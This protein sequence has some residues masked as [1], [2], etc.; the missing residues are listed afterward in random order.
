[1]NDEMLIELVSE[2]S[3]LFDL[4]NPKYMDTEY[5]NGIWNKI[6]I[7]MKMDGSSCKS[8]WNNIRD[9]YRKSLK[10]NKTVS[11]QKGKAAR[12]YKFSQHLSF[13]TNFFEDMDTI[14]NIDSETNQDSM[15]HDEVGEEKAATTSA[16]IS[17]LCEVSHSH[18]SPST[19]RSYKQSPSRMPKDGATPI[20]YTQSPR[21]K[22]RQFQQ[23]TTPSKIT[24]TAVLD[25][26]VRQKEF[27]ASPS[28]P[29]NE[30]DA[31][32]AGIA[33]ALKKMTPRYWHY[34]KGEL[35]ATVQKYELM[36][37]DNQQFSAP[38]LFS[39]EPLPSPTESSHINDSE[40]LHMLQSSNELCKQETIN[41]AG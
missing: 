4:S 7:E 8:R 11:V 40:E 31:F 37:M 14:T 39:D 23:I 25:Y 19:S 30:V 34:A 29:S 1:M 35:F 18:S 41:P 16:V 36:A 3:A 26:I 22:K 33:P 28:T 5:K 9:N 17:Q 32:L 2:N 24:A 15:D 12:P 38:L 21:R 20:S 13:L 10:K 27:M 6:G